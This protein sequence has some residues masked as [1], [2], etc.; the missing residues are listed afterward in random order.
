MLYGLQAIERVV[1][2]VGDRVLVKSWA[3]KAQNGIYTAGR[4]PMAAPLQAPL[5]HIW[6]P[7]ML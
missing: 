3:D 7:V 4:R 2:N 6:T 1:A 5:E